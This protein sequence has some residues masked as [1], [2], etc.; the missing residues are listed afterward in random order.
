MADFIT[1][2][3]CLSELGC[4]YEIDMASG[5]GFEYYTGVIFRFYCGEEALGGGGRY[6]DLIPLLG[7]GDVSASG[8]A[9]NVDQLMG[10]T[11]D[12]QDAK[13]TV[14]VRTGADTARAQKL[15]FDVAGLLRQAGYVAE[16]DRGYKRPT[17]HAWVLSV[18]VKGKSPVFVLTDRA[19]TSTIKVTSPNAIVDALQV[20]DAG[21]TGPS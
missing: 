12:W 3:E 21:E 11:E 13:P 16:L 6:N 19:G 9:L 10:L 2:A 4:E 1:I 7:G 18:Q 17:H 15:C 5:R 8:F 14:L 20:A